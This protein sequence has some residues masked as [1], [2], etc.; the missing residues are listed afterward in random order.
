[1]ETPGKILKEAREKKDIS[2]RE[3]GQA[4]K[5]GINFLKALENDEYDVFPNMV[6]LKSF[7]KNYAYFLDLDGE[8]MAREFKAGEFLSDE[9]PPPIR[10]N[11]IGHPARKLWAIGGTMIL[12]W[13]LWV[14]YQTM[15]VKF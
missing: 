1:M 9:N 8:K 5:I 14:L 15:V 11:N 6:Y 10:Y 13:L 7:L 4:T 12:I 3:A 2:L